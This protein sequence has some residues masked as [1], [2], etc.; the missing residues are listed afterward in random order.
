M[1][2]HP[3]DTSWPGHYL[4]RRLSRCPNPARLV[5]G[6]TI[7]RSLV[8]TFPRFACYFKY[9]RSSRPGWQ[10]T[11]VEGLLHS[12]NYCPLTERDAGRPLLSSLGSVGIPD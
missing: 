7:F 9:Y 3:I 2:L 6:L 8:L 5:D 11:K 10:D 12:L 4:F 1:A